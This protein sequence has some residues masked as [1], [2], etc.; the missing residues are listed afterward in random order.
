MMGI[1]YIDLFRNGSG[2][3]LQMEGVL[4]RKKSYLS[5][6]WLLETEFR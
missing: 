5:M 3:D 6:I 1:I 2:K 4:S